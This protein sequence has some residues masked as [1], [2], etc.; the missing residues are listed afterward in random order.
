MLVEDFQ[1]IQP[2]VVGISKSGL[3]V[4]FEIEPTE[5]ITILL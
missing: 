2:D 4:E 5:M 1:S 3:Q